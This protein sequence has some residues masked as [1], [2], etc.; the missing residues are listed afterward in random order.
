MADSF[1]DLSL[2]E[3][4]IKLKAIDNGDGTYSL[5]TAGSGSGGETVVSGVVSL[6]ASEAHLGEIG[7][8][9]TVASATLTRPGDTNAYAAKDVVANSTTAPTVV[10]FSGMARI[11]GSGG[12][13][14]KAR[15]LTNRSTDTAQFR[16]H[17][18]HTAPTAIADNAQMALVWANRT[19]RTGTLDFPALATEGTGSDSS[20]AL[21]AP[22]NTNFPLPFVCTAGDRNLYAIFETLSIFTPASGQL[23][24]IE[25]TADVN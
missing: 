13:I 8:R 19:N 16:M 4:D 11:A 2:V 21:L 25:L 17:L 9:F 7:G 14:T 18:Y 23:F 5:G 6:G 15:L 24:L 20:Y 12:Y 1:I 3:N 22:G 10:T